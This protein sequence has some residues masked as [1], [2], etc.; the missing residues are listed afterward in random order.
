S[1]KYNSVASLRLATAF[2]P[3]VLELPPL[4]PVALLYRPTLADGA[5]LRALRDVHIL[6]PVEHGRERPHDLTDRIASLF[7]VIILTDVSGWSSPPLCPSGDDYYVTFT[8]TTVRLSSYQD[9]AIKTAVEA[10]ADAVGEL[11]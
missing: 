7:V 1:S 3:L 4:R 11:A 6:F 9:D 5:D 10:W 8:R 2:A